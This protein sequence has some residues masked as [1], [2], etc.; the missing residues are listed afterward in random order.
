MTFIQRFGSALN[1]N[2]HLHLLVLDGGYAFSDGTAQFHCAL[3]PPQAE[4]ERLLDTFVRRITRTVVRAGALGEDPEQS[5]LDLEQGSALERL[6]ASAVRYRISVG[7]QAGRKTMTLRSASA[8][9][10]D[11]KRVKPLTAQRDGFSLNAAV[12]CNMDQREKLERVCRY[13]AR[14]PIALERLSV[15]GDGLM[16]YELKHAFRDGTTH[17]CCSSRWTLYRG[18]PRWWRARASIWFAITACLPRMPNTAATS[19]PR[20]RQRR[21]VLT[22]SLRPRRPSR[23]PR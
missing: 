19:S 6:A 5:W 10:R 2:V 18:W 20:C 21:H 7:P 3:A 14:V 16:V 1:L 17:V 8:V 13:V 23:A 12:A 9:A 22:N 15:D 4:L 11:G